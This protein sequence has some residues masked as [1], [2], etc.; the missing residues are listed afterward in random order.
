MIKAVIYTEKEKVCG[1]YIKGHA[2]Q[3]EHGKDIVCAAVSAI[4][5]TAL[6]TLDEMVSKPE[7]IEKDGEMNFFLK[8]QKNDDST[9]ICH[10]ILETVRVGLLQ[11]Q[12]EYPEHIEVKIEK[13]GFI[14]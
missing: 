9:L 12:Q 7:Y 6:G 11:I 14:G 8:R 1:F 2:G 10:T 13:G 4:A 3:G 5:Y